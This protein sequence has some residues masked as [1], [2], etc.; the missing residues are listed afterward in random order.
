[1]EVGYDG[2]LWT[3]GHSVRAW[4]EFVAMLAAARIEVVATCAVSP[5]PAA[6]RNSVAQTMG[7]A[8]AASDIAYVPMPEL[9]GRR[10]PR[11]DSPNLAWRNAGFRGYADY[12]Q[13]PDYRAARERLARDRRGRSG[14]Q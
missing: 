14:W 13:T 12:M 9:G 8:L 5:V 4:H 3:I 1:M 10:P 6:T 11:A 2:T 7:A